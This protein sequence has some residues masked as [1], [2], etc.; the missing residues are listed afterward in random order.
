[1]S[2][3]NTE[4]NYGLVARF[5]HW[6][7]AVAIFAMFALGLWMRSLDYYSPW[8]KTAPDIHKSIGILLLMALLFRFIWRFA[9][10][11][12]SDA[13]LE[14][15]ERIIS[16]IVHWVFYLLL[17]V[18]MSTGY[19]ISTVDG[20]AISVFGWF[21]VPSLYEQKGLEEQVGFIHEYLSYSLMALAALHIAAALKHHFVDGD[22][23]LRR[24]LFA[25]NSSSTPI[26]GQ[27]KGHQS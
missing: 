27:S 11:R 21:D 23:T 22:V 13:Y 6:S 5:L 3:R 18:H 1:M 26:K 7:M 14:P 25:S 19:L 20:R 24:M 9:N 8:Y 15:F 2:L 4:E 16:H 12:P 17:L 10:T